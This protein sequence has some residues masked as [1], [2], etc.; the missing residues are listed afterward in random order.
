MQGCRLGL[1]STESY[2]TAV[3]ATCYGLS[4][5]FGKT[6]AVLGT[7]AFT[8]IRN[9]LGARWTFIVAAICGVAGMLVTVFFIRNDLGG[10][11]AEEDARFAAFLEANGWSGEMG[12]P[13]AFDELVATE[14]GETSDD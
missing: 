14:K 11:L 4:I 13:E 9:N 6:G 12:T 2:A 8:P 7:Q 10:D 5:A 3:R 1:A